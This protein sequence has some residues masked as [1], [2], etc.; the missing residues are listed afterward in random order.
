MI[1]NSGDYSYIANE[2]LVCTVYFIWENIYN[3]H[4]S[5]NFEYWFNKTV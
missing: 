3:D 5:V 4:N 1:F 2:T